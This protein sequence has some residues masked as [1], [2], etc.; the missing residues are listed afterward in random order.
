MGSYFQ[1]DKIK[2][3]KIGQN[4]IIYLISSL[5]QKQ[6]ITNTNQLKDAK[7]T[8]TAEIKKNRYRETQ[9]FKTH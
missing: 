2:K 4:M 5:L 7:I 8:T 3:N 1:E 9:L 6:L